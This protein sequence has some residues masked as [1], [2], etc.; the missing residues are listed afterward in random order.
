MSGPP[1]A[2]GAA[3]SASALAG[4]PVPLGAVGA[5]VVVGAIAY[6]ALRALARWSS[7]PARPPSGPIGPTGAGAPGPTTA[8]AVAAVVP[9]PRSHRFALLLFATFLAAA[10][11]LLWFHV[12]I[13]RLW[14]HAVFDVGR[15]LFWP[16]PWPGFTP[17]AT[18]DGFLTD[19]I[20]LIY[21]AFLLAYVVASGLLW[22]PNY[23]LAARGRAGLLVV[24]YASTELLLDSV[25]FTVP[26]RFVASSFLLLRAL[27]GGAYFALLVLSTSLAPHPVRVEPVR[28]RDRRALPTLLL[29]GGIAVGLSVV[30][31]YLLFRYV[32]LGR[33]GFPLAVLL[34]LP[35]SAL[36]IWGALGRI[37]YDLN[38]VT[39]PRP[40]VAEFHPPVS[41]VIPA[42]D[43]EGQISDCL[44][45][46][47]AAAARYP[48]PTEILVANDGSSDGTSAAA[49][50]ALA[51]L[52]HARG[53][54]LDLDHGGK[55]H[56][57]NAALAAATGDIVIRLD[58]DAR[59]APE[60][61]FTEMVPHFADPDVGAVQ[62]EIL[63]RERTGWTRSL[64][65][66]EV[67]WSHLYLRRAMMA[68]R[69]A[70]VVDGV[71]SA[72]RRSDLASTG[73]WVPWNGEDTEVTLRL[74]RQGFRTRFEPGARALEDVP[75]DLSGLHRQRLR[76]NRGSLFA[77]RRHAGAVAGPALAFG[78]LAILFWFLLFSRG[79]LRTFVWAYAVASSV[80]L[81][82]P[83]L[84]HVA[85]IAVLLLIPRG[86]AVGYYL[87]RVGRAGAL[88]W[89]LA[90]PA[91]AALK[92][93]FQLE[94]FGTMGPGGPREIHR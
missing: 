81:G 73:G 59:I 91:F 48:G 43:E 82:L 9:A 51:D 26:G 61:S 15:A 78:G 89:L 8:G 31:L 52:A 2:V 34:L 37:V 71:F 85:V 88:P 23:S 38:L 49:S 19:L 58:A 18:A 22:D 42:F 44:A 28:P 93:L 40:S 35:M 86:I 32:G 94:A 76:W 53:R 56:A 20:F 7:G 68:M 27:T 11:P 72:F 77:H 64:R 50:A 90:W 60:S 65:L 10:I 54:L 66:L 41:V 14:G 5:I 80:L 47:D 25:F 84:L 63:P 79:G 33:E 12:E 57:L 69:T 75:A 29:T 62:G 21:L 1:T 74:E 6:L 55:A 70:E 87:G 13:L 36:T 46:V 30:L 39:H 4:V 45:S 92:Q 17:K 83:T 24:A 67:S 3:L 16:R